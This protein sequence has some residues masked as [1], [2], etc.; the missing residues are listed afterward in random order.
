MTPRPT[1]RPTPTPVPTASP[2]PTPAP[3]PIASQ[4]KYRVK[5]GDT[6]QKI[7]AHYG[8]KVPALMAAN[9]I[10]DAAAL[11]VGQVLTIP[12]KP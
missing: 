10:T 1:P 4:A 7:A 6:L 3:T 9:G 2:S 5:K 11:K 12:V 8:I